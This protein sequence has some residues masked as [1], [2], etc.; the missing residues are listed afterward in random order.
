M[1]SRLLNMIG[2]VLAPLPVRGKGRLTGFVFRHIKCD[3]IVCHP[4]RGVA[5]HL[6]PDMRIER[7]MWIGAY[8]PRLV[9]LLECILK[10]G[11]VFLDLGANIG[12]FS[13]IAAGLVGN[14][15]HVYAFEPNPSCLPLLRQNLMAF[16]WATVCPI[17]AG[18]EAADA[19]FYQSDRADEDGW[20]SLFCGENPRSALHVQVIRID[21][22]CQVHSVS[23][24]DFVKMDIEG[25]EYRALTGARN[26]LST[27]RPVII[28]EL[29]A[30]C[31]RR[32]NHSPGE[33]IQLLRSAN[34]E[35]F[36]FDD[37][38]FLALHREADEVRARLRR[39]LRKPANF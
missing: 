17:A 16:P 32:D 37:N 1:M 10:P 26:L 20:G 12:F 34:Y 39:Y 18:D 19:V 9:G 7:W 3:E 30:V 38:N 8:E 31:L 33:V 29:N 28:G 24:I 11:M 14:L 35:V 27:F 5:V 15:G 23:R 4:T 36:A 6:R 25:S 2:R 22:W 21:D 13:A